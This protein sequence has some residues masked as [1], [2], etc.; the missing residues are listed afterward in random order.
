M[1]LSMA[2][3][4]TNLVVVKFKNFLCWCKATGI[5]PSEPALD[6]FASTQEFIDPNPLFPALAD[7]TGNPINLEA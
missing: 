6:E 3:V 7:L 2:G 1:G 4:E 5:H